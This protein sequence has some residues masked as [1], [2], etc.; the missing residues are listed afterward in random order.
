MAYDDFDYS[1]PDFSYFRKKNQFDQYGG[2]GAMDDLSSIF[3]TNLPSKWTSPPVDDVY[4]GVEPQ[5]TALIRSAMQSQPDDSQPAGT[6]WTARY[7]ELYHPQYGAQNRLN[8]LLDAFPADEK[9]S[10]ARRMVAMGAGLGKG[11]IKDEQAILDEPNRTA[12]ER[13][14]MQA[15]PFQHAAETERQGNINERTLAQQSIQAGQNQQKIDQTEQKNRDT[16]EAARTRNAINRFKAENP[17]WTIDAKNGPNVIAYDPKNPTHRINLGPSGHLDDTDKIEAEGKWKV[18]A[19]EASGEAAIE[20]T[21]AAGTQAR[22]TK[23][24]VPGRADTPK[25]DAARVAET[26]KKIYYSDPSAQKFFSKAPDG[27]LTLKKGVEEGSI[28]YISWSSDDIAKYNSIVQEAYGTKAPTAKS[29]TDTPKQSSST[30]QVA[31]NTVPGQRLVVMGPD[32]TKKTIPAEQVQDF[33]KDPRYKGW[34]QV[35]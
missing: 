20:R 16:A 7:R 17:D 30:T 6:D 2:N 5:N 4:P 11:S 14:K 8:K 13:W 25:D 12:L 29:P 35:F 23:E 19:A 10:F 33:L 9:P 32:G 22:E 15:E 28:P 24:T 1:S 31:P 27:S 34:K 26:L 18:K 21:I 3:G